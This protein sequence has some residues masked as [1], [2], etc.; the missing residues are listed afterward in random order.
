MKIIEFLQ[1]GCGLK[2]KTSD[3]RGFN[4]GNWKGNRFDIDENLKSDIIGTMTDMSSLGSEGVDAIYS[5]HNIE[6]LYPQEMG[7]ALQE[8]H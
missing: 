1:A 2:T 3:T 4:L 7:T 6:H 5:S 8:L